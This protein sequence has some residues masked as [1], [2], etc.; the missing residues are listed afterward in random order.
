MFDELPM[1]E[2]GGSLP[3]K[4]KNRR[5]VA[6]ND[7]RYVKPKAREDNAA[8]VSVLVRIES[9]E[10]TVTKHEPV[11]HLVAYAPDHVLAHA[12]AAVYFR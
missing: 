3:Y 5:Q 12:V 2:T 1:L 9:N 6:A 8:I 11:D 7:R 4:L 10:L